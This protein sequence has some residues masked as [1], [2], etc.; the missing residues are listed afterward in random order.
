VIILLSL[1]DSG[2]PPN[3]TLFDTV[4]RI[5]KTAGQ[6]ATLRTIIVGAQTIQIVWLHNNSNINTTNNDHYRLTEFETR[7]GIFSTL[8]ILGFG[9]ADQGTYQIMAW[10]SHG[11]IETPPVTLSLGKQLQW[12]ALCKQCILGP[13]SSAIEPKCVCVH[14]GYY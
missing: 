4:G 7:G 3:V 13:I 14:M 6:D 5:Y 11:T 9:E 10:N 2:G 12:P 1:C 8:K